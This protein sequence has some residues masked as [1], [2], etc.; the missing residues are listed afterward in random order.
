MRE[1]DKKE[2]TGD[3]VKG[4][5]DTKHLC[6]GPDLRQPDG[7]NHQQQGDTSSLEVAE[8]LVAFCTGEENDPQ[9]IEESDREEEGHDQTPHLATD[10]DRDRDRQRHMQGQGD[11][12]KETERQRQTETERETYTETRRQEERKIEIQQAINSNRQRHV[13]RGT[14]GDRDRERTRGR[15]GQ[16]Q[17]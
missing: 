11:T 1:R 14:A 4:T 9:P 6:L 3:R 15:M 12:N 10:R 13:A 8:L 2:E 7:S 17:R 16:R 5:R